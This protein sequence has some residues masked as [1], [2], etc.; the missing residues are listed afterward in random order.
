MLV[1]A[2]SNVF[3]VFPL[4]TTPPHTQMTLGVPTTCNF[5]HSAAWQLSRTEK[6]ALSNVI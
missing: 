3:L 4:V 2:F 6:Q 1:L 5:L